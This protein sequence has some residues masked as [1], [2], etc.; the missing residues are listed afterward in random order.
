MLLCLQ[1]MR[2]REQPISRSPPRAQTSLTSLLDDF[3]RPT[4]P[5]DGAGGYGDDRI[6]N[7]LLEEICSDIGIKDTMDLDFLDFDGPDVPYF[8]KFSEEGDA[9]DQ[10]IPF[11]QMQSQLQYGSKEYMSERMPQ[12]NGRQHQ[13]NMGSGG[14][15]GNMG[16]GPSSTVSSRHTNNGES[17][18]SPTV[19]STSSGSKSDG[20]ESARPCSRE[21]VDSPAMVHST[22]HNRGMLPPGSVESQVASSPLDA[23]HDMGKLKSSRASSFDSL[24]DSPVTVIE[25]DTKDRGKIVPDVI[26]LDDIIP[27]PRPPSRQNQVVPNDDGRPAEKRL[28]RTAAAMPSPRKPL[29]HFS[30]ENLHTSKASCNLTKT[31]SSSCSNL[32]GGNQYG[33]MSMPGRKPLQSPSVGTSVSMAGMSSSMTNITTKCSMSS[34]S[35]KKEPDDGRRSRPSS[36]DPENAETCYSKLSSD[37]MRHR[38]TDSPY[39]QGYSTGSCATSVCTGSQGSHGSHGSQFGSTNSLDRANNHAQPDCHYQDKLGRY[40]RGQ[41]LPSGV[42]NF[43]P[44]TPISQAASARVPSSGTS[45]QPDSPPQERVAKRART[46]NNGSDLL[47]T[48]REQYSFV[49]GAD[50]YAKPRYPQVPVQRSRPTPCMQ[51]Q[52]GVNA[53]GRPTSTDGGGMGMTGSGGWPQ[54]QGQYPQPMSSC[55]QGASTMPAGQNSCQ[56][57]QQDMSQ[58]AGFGGNQMQ[59]QDTQQYNKNMYGQGMQNAQS[60]GF[61]M[62]NYPDRTGF[63]GRAPVA[64]SRMSCQEGRAQGMSPAQGIPP[65][66]GYQNAQQ[67][68]MQ[69]AQQYPPQ[70][71]YA[72]MN[73][74]PTQ[75]LSQP[76]GISVNGMTPSDCNGGQWQQQPNLDQSGM[77][78]NAESKGMGGE[79]CGGMGMAG[80]AHG[81]QYG[82]MAGQ[83]GMYPMTPGQRQAPNPAQPAQ[84]M[85]GRGMMPGQMGSSTHPGP[86]SCM[87]PSGQPPITSQELIRDIAQPQR[88]QGPGM[89]QQLMTDRSSAFRSHPLFPLLRDLII[90]DMNFHS[91]SFP[92]A[93]IANL[94]PD[95]DK[96]LQNYLNRNP[97]QQNYQGNPAVQNVI[98]DALKYAHKALIGE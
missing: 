97:P 58:M 53:P 72:N 63:G 31:E 80:Q 18:A 57:P 68:N 78:G 13:A 81:G 28:A 96:L 89:M 45:S 4:S 33:N 60:E 50:M 84:Q 20:A 88:S 26:N 43:I 74:Q 6:H 54:G 82:Q 38:S 67:G 36:V 83:P 52:G 7:D 27:S 11:G 94:P 46:I 59:T 79:G 15:R 47:E 65:T 2:Y 41:Q 30:H 91:P 44:P 61:A 34:P 29:H 69:C 5:P 32:Y 17:I 39:D 64:Q 85:P 10:T 73:G 35:I 19:S 3:E 23:N 51:Q 24:V 55:A 77:Y 93:L 1:A 42:P 98:M 37:G 40:M 62:P 90:A 86:A 8:T 22:T 92:F 95:F 49:K 12:P 87:D 16:P 76:Q 25:A 66:Q 14:Q 48:V 75:R 71:P 56:T 9:F 70:S 21:P